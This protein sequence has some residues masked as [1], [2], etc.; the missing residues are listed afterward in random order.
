MTWVVTIWTMWHIH[1]C[2][3]SWLSIV[4]VVTG[5][6]HTVVVVGVHSGHWGGQAHQYLCI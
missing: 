1:E 5:R 4:V 2:A 3:R 6:C